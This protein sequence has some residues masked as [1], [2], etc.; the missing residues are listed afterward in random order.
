MSAKLCI[1][2]KHYQ[3]HSGGICVSPEHARVDLVDG[4][5]RGLTCGVLRGPPHHCGPEGRDF[6]PKHPGL[7]DERW[8]FW[9]AIKKLFKGEGHA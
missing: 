9:I 5:T 8:G 2:C 7:E 4:P 6:E 1:N 3:T